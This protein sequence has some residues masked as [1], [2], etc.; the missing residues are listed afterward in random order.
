MLG[1]VG[2]GASVRAAEA[3]PLK[4]AQAKQDDRCTQADVLEGR[5][6]TDRAGAERHADER[7]DE[8][9]FAADAISQPAEYECP[10]RTDQ[11]SGGEQRNRAEQRRHGVAL[12][13]EFYRENRGQAP[14]NVEVIP[15]DD[16]ASGRSHDHGPEVLRNSSCLIQSHLSHVVLL[17]GFITSPSSKT[18][19][20]YRASWSF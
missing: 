13:E 9:V 4:H 14:E 20:Q 11:K 10:Q 3:K 5:D 15:L 7:Q 19:P 18:F 17:Q 12:F 1:D 2:N 8:G 16:I 6:E